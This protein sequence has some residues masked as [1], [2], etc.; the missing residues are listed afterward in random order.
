MALDPRTPVVVGV[1]QQGHRLDDPATAVEPVVLMEQMVRA[2]AADAGAPGLVAD[3][4]AVVVVAGAWRYTDP[5]RMIA[6]A[7]GA[8]RARTMLSTAGGNTPQSLVNILAARIQAGQLDSVVITGAETIWS[9]RRRRRADL[10]NNMSHQDPAAT[11]DERLGSE[12]SLSHEFEQRRGLE[13]PINYYPIFES[14]IRAEAG[15]SIEDHRRRISELWAGFNRVAVANPHAWFRTPMTA[16]QIRTATP[17]N[18]MIGFPYTKAMNANWDLD[19]GAAIVLCS[20]EA[21]RAA[22]IE[23]DRWVFPWAGVDGHDTDAVSHRRDLH[24][25][26]AIG[27]CGRRLFAHTERDVDDLAHIDLYSCFPSAVQVGADELGLDQHR[28]L[29]VTGGLTFAGG[30][31]NNYVS[32]AIVTM[33]DL[34]R[35]DAGSLGLVTAN[36]GFLTKHALGLYSTEPF[37]GPF[38][39]HNVQDEV[40]RVPATPLAA[41]H[42]GPVTIE[43]YT[44]MHDPNGPTVALAALRVARESGSARTWGTTTDP[45]VLGELMVREGVGRAATVDTQ[46]HFELLD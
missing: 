5:G 24:S 28:Q 18:R 7:L 39:A 20:V 45:D 32:H 43:A 35:R 15:E 34:L 22:G 27:A 38:V 1:A 9:R 6:D 3:L 33:V 37:T 46:G 2:A 41:D 44:V 29:T 23:S 21:A 14:A 42:I 11:P 13:A 31:L 17:E 25:S 4:D 40:D 26:P 19:Q 10:P 16:E 8:H 30:P 12:L 36:G